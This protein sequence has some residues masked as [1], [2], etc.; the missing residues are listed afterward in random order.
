MPSSGKT[1]NIG[2]NLWSGS[3]SP[4]M[5]DF[6]SDNTIIDSAIKALQD[7]GG[8]GGSGGLSLVLG[9][10]IGDGKETKT[11]QWESRPKF[12]V[13]FASGKPVCVTVEDGQTTQ[14]S[15]VFGSEYGQSVGSYPYD[16][17]L[18]LFYESEGWDGYRMNMNQQGVTYCYML[19][20]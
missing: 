5:E 19:F 20:Y 8:G 14:V 4:K 17:R 3:D 9:S 16:D 7:Q 13:V 15:L 18:E 12:W 11:I 10:Y 2:L 1:P 6:N